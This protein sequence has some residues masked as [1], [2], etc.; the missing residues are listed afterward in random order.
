M[1]RKIQTYGLFALLCV[2]AACA[3]VRNPQGGQKDDKPPVVLV[4]Y[5][6]PMSIQFN[7]KSITFL[8]DEYVKLNDINTNLVISPPLQTKPKIK[9]R[10]KYV[11]IEL[12]EDLLP[13]TT[14][15]FNFGDGIVDV[16]ESNKAQDLVY[17]FSTGDVIDSLFAAGQVWDVFNDV[18]AKN[19]KVMAFE[20]DTSIFS[21]KSTPLYFTRTKEDGSF[22]MPYMREGDFFL[23][24]LDDQNNNYRWDDGEAIGILKD[25]INPLNDT[26]PVR[27]EVSIPRAEKLYIN[28]FKTD[29]VGTMKFALDAFYTDV[30]ATAL[31]QELTTQV[32]RTT[33]SV[34]VWLKGAPT[35]KRESVG[36]KVGELFADTL[37]IIYHTDALKNN[38]RIAKPERD[39]IKS[40]EKLVIKSRALITLKDESKISLIQDSI[41]TPFVLE[42]DSLRFQNTLKAAF[43]AGKNY[44]LNVYPD[45]FENVQSATNDTLKFSFSIL[46]QE[47]LGNLI[48]DLK[49]PDSLVF[50][51]LMILDKSNSLVFEKVNVRSETIT[52]SSLLAGDYSLKILDDRNQNGMYDPVDLKNGTAPE[53]M[54]I[55]SAKVS[56]RANWDLKT[57]WD[58]KQSL[59]IED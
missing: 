22:L 21:K 18:A 11:I 50:G 28:D 3:N 32:Y 37:D 52:I 44:E 39:K 56:L 33:D 27:F 38:F 10:K 48:L 58:I 16:N 47:D 12:Q 45:A 40:D 20:N 5:P 41:P 34:Y 14:Y 25:R 54:Y 19:F 51:K 7:S 35:D 31:N 30:S 23:Y 4:A 26:L 24:A 49:I 53:I 17:V 42:Y 13:N 46:K 6:Q 36:I 29:S 1:I 55:Y 57:E 8:F 9:V 43:K 2:L 15:M 59:K